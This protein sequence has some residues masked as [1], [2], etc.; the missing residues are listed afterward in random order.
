[1][2]FPPEVGM[3][4]TQCF[5]FVDLGYCCDLDSQG[6]GYSPGAQPVSCSPS[7]HCPRLCGHSE[8]WGAYVARVPLRNTE[9]LCEGSS[10]ACVSDGVRVERGM[11]ARER[12]GGSMG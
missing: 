2:L 1:M 3:A 5:D 12:G 10:Q 6:T 7:G 4:R 8:C 9:V 11:S